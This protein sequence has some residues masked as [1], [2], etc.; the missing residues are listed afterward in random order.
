MNLEA[1]VA[2][3]FI[4]P[5]NILVLINFQWM[6]SDQF[7]NL[8]IIAPGMSLIY[9]NLYCVIWRLQGAMS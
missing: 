6:L 9:S 8:D 1:N 3:G 2:Q 5:G 7:A 4:D